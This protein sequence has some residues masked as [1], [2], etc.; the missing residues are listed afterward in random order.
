[1]KDIVVSIKTFLR[2]EHL[3]NCVHSVKKYLPGV[4]IAICDDGH[5]NKKKDEFYKILRNEGHY[6]FTL[7]FDIGM[8]KGRNYI[9]EHTEESYILYMDDDYI[10]SPETKIYNFYEVLKHRPDI[11]MIGG[12]FQ[13]QG[14]INEYQGHIVIKKQVLYQIPLAMDN[15]DTISEVR[16]KL[17]DLTNNFYL[18]RRSVVDN[19]KFDDTLKI[20]TAHMDYFM[21]VKKGGWNIAF[22]PDVIIEHDHRLESGKDGLYEGYRSRVGP[23]LR[24]FADKHHLTRAYY[25]NGRV[26]NYKTLK[27]RESFRSK[28][29]RFIKKTGATHLFNNDFLRDRKG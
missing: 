13:T 17:C 25:F 23:G 28:F 21:S 8:M 22:T 19:V 29:A 6:I 10:M 12:R 18:I 3:Y 15:W 7:P 11:G 9:I 20:G 16:F 27:E 26:R 1:M 14:K 5:M 4:K 24:Y 2:D